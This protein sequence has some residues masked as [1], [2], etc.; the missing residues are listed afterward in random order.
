MGFVVFALSR[1][2]YVGWLIYLIASPLYIVF[3]GR[4][5]GL[6]YEEG[7]PKPTP[8]E[9]V[10]AAVEAK[11]CIQCGAKIPADARFCPICGAAQE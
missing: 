3:V 11:F 6:I 1:I 7:A 8:R 2:P 10:E 4:S 5:F 9:I